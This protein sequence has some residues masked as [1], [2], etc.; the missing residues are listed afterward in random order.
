MCVRVWC[1]GCVREHQQGNKWRWEG[2][3]TETGGNQQAR[4]RGGLGS[5][6]CL[7]SLWR[8]SK[9]RFE[10]VNEEIGGHCRGFHRTKSPG[11]VGGGG[12]GGAVPLR[13]CACL[14]MRTL[15]RI[16]GQHC[17]TMLPTSVEGCWR[18][19]VPGAWCSVFNQRQDEDKW[20]GGTSCSSLPSKRSTS[21]ILF[22][23]FGFGSPESGSDR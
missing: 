16:Q 2:P 19:Q 6:F 12:G 18:K 14:S 17:L 8:G 11:H 7:C 3:S 5:V 15:S 21:A 9:L 22:H 23:R 10:E 13:M 4:G 20:M 1:V